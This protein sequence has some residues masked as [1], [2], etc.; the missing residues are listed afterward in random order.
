M[1]YA[2]LYHTVGFILVVLTYQVVKSNYDKLPEKVPIHFGISMKAD[3]W[4][5]KS[6][7]TAYLLFYINLGIWIL[8]LFFTFQ[9]FR[10][11]PI[12][13]E[14]FWGMFSAG[15]SFLLYYLQVGII[16]YALGEIKNI[17]LYFFIGLGVFILSTVIPKFLS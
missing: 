1:Y 16:K 6:H 2:I 8:Y 12:E 4:A 10:S 9:V 17:T 3:R 13:P 14:W 7:I 11:S 5:K 15:I